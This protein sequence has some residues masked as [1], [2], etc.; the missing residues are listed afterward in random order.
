MKKNYQHILFLFVTVLFISFT[1]RYQADLKVGL[2]PYQEV[3]TIDGVWMEVDSATISFEGA[4]FVIHNMTERTDLDTGP[5]FCIEKRRG[6]AWYTLPLLSGGPWDG[7]LVAW[8]IPPDSSG[9]P[10]SY[11]CDWTQTY[12][13]LPPGN[14]RLLKEVTSLLD[15]PLSEDSP[16][17]YLSA[18]FAVG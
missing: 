12:G 17:Y 14:Y 6:R 11:K 13:E 16:R 3:D 9:R 4:V 2:S 10:L 5:G 18:P 15:V 8:P 1:W 7:P